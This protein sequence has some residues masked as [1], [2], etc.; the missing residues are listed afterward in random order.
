MVEYLGSV[1]D[2]CKVTIGGHLTYSSVGCSP[3]GYLIFRD[4]ILNFSMVFGDKVANLTCSSML[5][6][7]KQLSV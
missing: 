4:S 6:K 1:E 7:S 3:S 2:K 5:T